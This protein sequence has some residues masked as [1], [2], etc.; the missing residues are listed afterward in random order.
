MEVVYEPTSPEM[1]VF[2]RRVQEGDMSSIMLLCGMIERIYGEAPYVGMFRAISDILLNGKAKL[3]NLDE[4]VYEFTA[5]GMDL[6]EKELTIQML[7]GAWENDV[8]KL[9]HFCRNFYTADKDVRTE[10]D[11]Q[12]ETIR[13]FLQYERA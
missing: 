8:P 3:G 12:Q 6:R 1:E 10:G 5:P 2:A 7:E 4:L 13:V 9:L 11:Y